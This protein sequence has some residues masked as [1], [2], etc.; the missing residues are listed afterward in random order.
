MIYFTSDNHWGHTNII[1]FS[2]RPFNTVEEM[3]RF[4]VESWNRIVQPEDEIYHLGDFSFKISKRSARYIL[5]KL[6]GKKYLIKGNH[7]RIEYINNFK[8]IG[9][10][11]WWKDYHELSYEH[12]G[13]TYDF[14]LN[15]Y[16]HYPIKINDIICIHGHSHGNEH[17]G[18][19]HKSPEVLDVG[20]DNIGY[21]PISII[22]I[23]ELIERR[24]KN[25]EIQR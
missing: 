3:N 16:P 9:L 5:S 20:V 12:G 2:N 11:E 21:E 8:N 7:D 6:N 4:M 1:R 15:H 22:N 25:Y 24:R 18:Q 10:I 23:I 19:N 13:K 14:S 17:R